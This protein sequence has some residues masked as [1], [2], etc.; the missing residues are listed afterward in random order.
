MYELQR[1]SIVVDSVGF[2]RA[3]LCTA[4]RALGFQVEAAADYDEALKLLTELEVDLL[5]VDVKAS[6]LRDAR[7]AELAAYAR[8]GTAVVL[9][10]DSRLPRRFGDASPDATLACATKSGV[11]SPDQFRRIVEAAIRGERTP[12]PDHALHLVTAAQYEILTLI[13]AGHSNP[14]IAELLGMNRRALEHAIRRIYRAVGLVPAPESNLRVAA[15]T[16]FNRG[17]IGFGGRVDPDPALRGC[18]NR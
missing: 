14:A 4:V 5:V 7:L 8:R 9:F 18:A 3:T 1:F 15:V 11:N 16:M 2:S 13:A 12:A 17:E 10:G 6:D